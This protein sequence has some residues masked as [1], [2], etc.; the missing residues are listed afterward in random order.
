MPTL[1]YTRTIDAAA[2]PQRAKRSTTRALGVRTVLARALAQAGAA[3]AAATALAGAGWATF[4]GA[5]LATMPDMHAAHAC[6]GLA[7][8]GA[9]AATC[10]GWALHL[11]D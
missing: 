6:A 4:G 3:L 1:D 2:L 8:L 7:M 5:M 9:S 11:G 10:I